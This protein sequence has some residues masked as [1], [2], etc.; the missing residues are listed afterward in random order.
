MIFTL[1]VRDEVDGSVVVAGRGEM[2]GHYDSE[3]AS[4]ALSVVSA[5]LAA[6]RVARAAADGNESAR[7]VVDI[8]ATYVSEKHV[9]MLMDGKSGDKAVH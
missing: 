8:L 2:N 4:G 3:T 5:M 6:V 7:A 1:V 9:A